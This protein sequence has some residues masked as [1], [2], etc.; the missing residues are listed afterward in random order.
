MRLALGRSRIAMRHSST[1]ALATLALLAS[2]GC[3]TQAT[4][5]AFALDRW[6]DNPGPPG[7]VAKVTGAS[8][9]VLEDRLSVVVAVERQ[10]AREQ[11]F[12]APLQD[13]G[14][15]SHERRFAPVEITAL[16][17][18]LV[19]VFYTTRVPGEDGFA[20]RSERFWAFLQVASSAAILDH[21]NGAWNP[22][23]P[24][25][26]TRADFE[27]GAFVS[28]SRDGRGSLH[29]RV[30]VPD[31]GRRP[32]RE[33]QWGFAPEIDDEA[34]IAIESA[35]PS[36]GHVEPASCPWLF[37]LLSPLTL[38]LDAVPWVAEV[39]LL[40]LTLPLN[41]LVPLPAW[42]FPLVVFSGC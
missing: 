2:S 26:P 21:D 16:P 33:T 20:H 22:A 5:H 11:F 15:A 34:R 41:A 17:E 31:S 3:V 40:P 27:R 32:V 10:D 1:L 29:F 42:V 35:P 24:L 8:I 12:A 38:T 23:Q 13:G 7:A 19:P 9:A 36:T 39:A 28:A 37:Y 30:S 18:T 14:A 6:I 25:I 4:G